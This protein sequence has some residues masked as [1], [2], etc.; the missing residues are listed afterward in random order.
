MRSVYLSVRAMG[1][2]PRGGGVDGAG[3]G[4]VPVVG[5]NIHSNG[6]TQ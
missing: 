6:A 4:V 5:A 1:R 3:D 2:V